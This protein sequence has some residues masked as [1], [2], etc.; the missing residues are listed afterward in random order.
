MLSLMTI[1][2]VGFAGDPEQPDDRRG[3]SCIRQRSYAG[4][5]DLYRLDAGRSGVKKR[6]AIE[7]C[8]IREDKISGKRI[9]YFFDGKIKFW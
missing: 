1:T 8:R 4:L 5:W 3:D 6:R 2:R 7:E 9:L